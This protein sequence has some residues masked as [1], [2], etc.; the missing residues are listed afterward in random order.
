[1]YR[2]YCWWPKCVIVSYVHLFF[3][4]PPRIELGTYTLRMCRST[5]WAKAA[6]LFY[7]R[8]PL[9]VTRL[10]FAL[11]PRPLPLLRAANVGVN[12]SQFGHRS[13]KLL[14]L[15]F[16]QSPSTWSATKGTIPDFWFICAH[17]HRQQRFEYFLLRNFFICLET[18]PIF[19]SP[20]TFPCVQF[21]INWRYWYSCWQVLLQYL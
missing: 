15:L 20:G 3:E 14:S 12:E 7:T 4:P 16:V 1:M 6:C 11:F 8:Y 2:I 21:L 17:P 18:T 10:L 9:V 19:R 5:N 13:L